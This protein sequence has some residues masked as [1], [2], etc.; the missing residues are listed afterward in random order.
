MSDFL[1]DVIQGLNTPDKYLL[2]KYFYDEEGD[3]LFQSIMQLEE[4]Y[5][6]KAEIDIFENQKAKICSMF[7]KQNFRLAEMGAG[8]GT[9]TQIILQE[10]LERNLTFSYHPIDIS[11]NV[12]KILEKDLK[13]QMP[14][15]S[16]KG[17]A[18]EYFTALGHLAEMGDQALV[19]LFL[20]SNLGNFRRDNVD[21][22]MSQ[23]SASLHRGDLFIL[24]IDLKKSPRKIL[25]AYNDS[26]GVT[27][28][29][30]FN[31][32]KRINRELGGNFQVNKFRH[33][34]TY[35]PQS[36]ECRSYLISSEKQEVYIKAAQQSF[37]FEAFEAIHTETSRKYNQTELDALALKHGFQRKETLLDSKEQYS[38]QIWEKS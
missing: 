19:V 24:G 3:R 8:D 22:F 15:L 38:T 4:Y 10:A 28:A 34:N 13:K 1:K 14:S 9:K 16:V 30:N 5:L 17:L 20:G 23:L 36:G 29:F 2:S 18:N 31:V 7:P 12:L 11:P 25:D 26:L 37:K 6:T 35:N 27:A 32:L 33:Y 21:N